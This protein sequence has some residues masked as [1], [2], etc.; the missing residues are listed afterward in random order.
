MEL[1]EE[2]QLCLTG[3][4]K[5]DAFL[6]NWDMRGFEIKKDSI[7]FCESTDEVPPQK[8]VETF[9]GFNRE[10]EDGGADK[11][12]DFCLV[13]FFANAKQ[14]FILRMV[15]IQEREENAVFMA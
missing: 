15:A 11:S 9:R 14:G 8:V 3:I 12:P 4:A 2:Q 13:I 6:Q 10:L 7:R 5:C 1:T